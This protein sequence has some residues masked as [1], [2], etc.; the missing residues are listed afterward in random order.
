[1]NNGTK[2]AVGIFVVTFAVTL[3]V[4]R[5]MMQMNADSSTT[6]TPKGV[7]WVDP[8]HP[9]GPTCVAIV[10]RL[11]K[12]PIALADAVAATRPD[13]LGRTSMAELVVACEQFGLHAAAVE[14]RAGQMHKLRIPAIA[15]TNYEHFLVLVPNRSGNL[16]VL[17][18]PRQPSQPDP[19]ALQTMCSGKLILVGAT[20]SELDGA[21]TA[22]GLTRRSKTRGG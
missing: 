2:N 3:V 13:S 5:F 22:F 17:D 20:E 19:V 10:G 1:M 12:R 6:A 21:L 14:V 11:N 18:P 16:M 15:H 8:K 9:C 7:P 4:N